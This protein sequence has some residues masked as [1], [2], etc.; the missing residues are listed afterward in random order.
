MSI[1]VPLEGF[2]GG[3]ANLNFKILDY[4]TKAALLAAAPKE[5][6]IGIIT[7][8]PITAYAFAAA[9]PTEPV[10]GMV[11]IEVG[12]SGSLILNALKKNG[13]I[14]HLVRAKQYASGQWVGVEAYIYQGGAWTNLFG[15]LFYESGTF[16]TEHTNYLV[17]DTAVVEENDAFIHL[18]T[19]AKKTSEVYKV[20]GPV[21]LSG[22]NTLTM[23]SAFTDT[24][25][26]S[27]RRV[28]YVAKSPDVGC[29]KADAIETLDYTSG[30]TAEVTI[31]LDVSDLT[32][33]YYVY[34]GT[35]TAGSAWDNARKLNITKVTGE[36]SDVTAAKASAYDILTKGVTAE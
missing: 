32:S 20:F 35:N 17:P 30:W 6:T 25:S 8:T 19:V 2:G 27:H 18:A 1:V 22:I 13:I 24:V 23:T 34:A 12:I 28:L 21:S 26:G 11:W 5:N 7:E 16:Y 10:E 4:A 9:E 31:T 14:L 36:D 3:G 29:A 33:E 15:G